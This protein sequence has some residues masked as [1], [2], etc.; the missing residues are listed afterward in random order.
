[1]MKVLFVHPDEKLAQVYRPYLLQHF[2]VDSATDGLS[3]LRRLKTFA[4]NLVVSD[5]Q[6]PHVSGL[7]FLKFVRSSPEYNRTPF[8]FL[9]N[10]HDPNLA[11]SSGASD[12][13]DVKTSTPDLL[14]QKIYHH[15]KIHAI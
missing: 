9:T 4:P 10:Y 15:L 12:W 14:V 7:A 13:L 1:M 5:Y 3:G 2:Q 8:I 6:M 11:L